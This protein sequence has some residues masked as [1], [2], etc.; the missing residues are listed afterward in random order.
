VM[1]TTLYREQSTTWKSPLQVK[2]LTTIQDIHLNQL[3]ENLL[4]KLRVVVNCRFVE[5]YIAN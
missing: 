3:K 5:P 4:Q 1:Y 2:F